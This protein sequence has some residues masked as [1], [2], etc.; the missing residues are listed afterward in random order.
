MRH[1][2]RPCYLPLKKHG[3]LGQPTGMYLVQALS[4]PRGDPLRKLQLKLFFIGVVYMVVGASTLMGVL[5]V[6]INL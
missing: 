2:K 1:E 3:L 5:I 6:A 4:R